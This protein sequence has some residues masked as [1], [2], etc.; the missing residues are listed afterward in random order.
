MGGTLSEFSGIDVDHVLN[1]VMEETGIKSA[2]L[3]KYVNDMLAIVDRDEVKVFLAALNVVHGKLKFT[4]EWKKNWRIS[5]LDL[6]I[7]RRN[8]SL[9]I[10]WYRKQ[11]SKNIMLKSWHLARINTM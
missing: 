6:T 4:C 9:T 11:L 1:K 2:P 3:V 5:Y 10:K 8:G 7:I